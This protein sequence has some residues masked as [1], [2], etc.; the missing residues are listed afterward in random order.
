MQEHK[1]LSQWIIPEKNLFR[2]GFQ[3]T[4][5]SLYDYYGFV[6]T[7]GWFCFTTALEAVSTFESWK[8][9]RAEIFALLPSRLL[10]KHAAPICKRLRSDTIFWLIIKPAD[11]SRGSMI[12]TFFLTQPLPVYACVCVCVCVFV[13]VC[14]G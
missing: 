8:V 7:G 3:E 4:Y 10:S 13:N 6:M 2:E 14:T 5:Y 11:T 9:E 12:V 1:N